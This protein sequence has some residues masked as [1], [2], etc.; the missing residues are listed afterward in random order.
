MTNKLQ[1]NSKKLCFKKGGV[2]IRGLVLMINILFVDQ[3][4]KKNNF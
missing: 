3:K 4:K 2:F 1:K